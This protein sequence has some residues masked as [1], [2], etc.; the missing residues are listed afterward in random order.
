MKH[1]AFFAESIRRELASGAAAAEADKAAAVEALRVHRAGRVP[2]VSSAGRTKLFE[3]LQK[4]AAPLP[5]AQVAHSIESIAQ[6]MRYEETYYTYV[7]VRG[8]EW[9]GI[10]VQICASLIDWVEPA[11]TGDGAPVANRC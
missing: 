2:R 1:I 7:R 9:P 11:D 6:F 3:Q 5:V 10:R 4:V 8:G